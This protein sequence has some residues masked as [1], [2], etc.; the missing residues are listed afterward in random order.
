MNNAFLL[1]ELNST[2]REI[3]T[4]A[5]HEGLH[6][7][8]R[9][10]FGTNAASEIL[11]EKMDE[12][13]ENR[14]NCL[15]IADDVILFVTAFDTIYHTLDKVLNQF[16]ECGITLNKQ[17]C[18]L[19]INKAEFFGFV[20]TEKVI[21]SCH[22]KIE[23]IQNMPPPTNI[24]ELSSFLGMTNYFKSFY[25]KLFYAYIPFTRNNKEKYSLVV[26][27]QVPDYFWWFENRT[28]FA[29]VMSYYDPSL[30]SL[31]NT[32]IVL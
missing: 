25:T 18:E 20:F 9:L 27:T 19:F 4:F 2:S 23:S 5:A 29:K 31:I 12:I 30:N 3:T 22:T 14:P 8:K 24:S 26:D 17:K 32:D 1:F 13:L 10:N 7:F 16:L 11:Q 28:Y 21:T 15:A 6:R